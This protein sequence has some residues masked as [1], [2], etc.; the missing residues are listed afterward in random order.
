MDEISHTKINRYVILY[1]K[2]YEIVGDNF[3]KAFPV[4]ISELVQKNLITEKES[5]IILDIVDIYN[6][7]NPLTR[8]R[9]YLSIYNK[10]S[11]TSNL[12]EKM[13]IIN[14]FPITQD[15]KN[16]FGELFNIDTSKKI[17]SMNEF[18]NMLYSYRNLYII[19]N[20]NHGKENNV[21]I[22]DLLKSQEA[23]NKFIFSLNKPLF[24]FYVASD[25]G[26]I[27][28]YS[29]KYNKAT[30]ILNNI[31]YKEFFNELQRE[32]MK[33]DIDLE[34]DNVCQDIELELEF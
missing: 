2:N 30:E 6:T 3:N 12:F 33:R 14:K 16:I 22:G 18:K 1:Y 21:R 32:G 27:N 10:L 29:F 26:S 20:V 23:L 7:K 28:K 11:K 15:I 8:I 13:E 9:E 24:K 31:A 25:I 5:K 34:N 19:Y 4:L 17:I